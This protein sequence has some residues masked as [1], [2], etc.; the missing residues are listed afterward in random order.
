MQDPNNFEAYDPGGISA[1]ITPV[2]V[3]CQASAPFTPRDVLVGQLAAL[4]P[5]I[6]QSTLETVAD[7]LI[8]LGYGLPD[9]AAV[10][11]QLGAHQFV[12]EEDGD[13]WIEPRACWYRCSCSKR[14]YSGW[15]Q[16]DP[17]LTGLEEFRSEG[18]GAA[19]KLHHA[20]VVAIITGIAPA[21]VPVAEY[22][23]VLTEDAIEAGA[24]QLRSQLHD[25][26]SPDILMRKRSK[27]VLRAAIP[28]LG[29]EQVR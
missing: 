7:G 28:Y 21:E 29:V 20:H 23:P 18:Y 8:T 9:P 2:R 27:F 5:G 25:F 15:T 16:I 11:V 22:H 3:P 4:L 17:A 26:T 1:K 24:N 12:E 6:F 14:E 10:M 13:G 19:L